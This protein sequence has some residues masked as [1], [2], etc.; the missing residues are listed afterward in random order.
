MIDWMNCLNWKKN[1]KRKQKQKK[2]E[3][4]M[5][6]NKNL[7]LEF[8]FVIVSFHLSWSVKGNMTPS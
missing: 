2:T 4:K 3:N 6:H 5:I 8:F 7:D 1:H